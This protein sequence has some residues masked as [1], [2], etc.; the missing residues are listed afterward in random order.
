[1]NRIH[2]A[3]ARFVCGALCIALAFA[4]TP[5]PATAGPNNVDLRA[6]YYTDMEAVSLGGGMLT[7]MGSGWF[8]NPNAE[9]AFGDGGNLLTLNGDFHYDFPTDATVS[10]YLGAG[11]GLLYV[12]PDFGDSDT[13]FG[14]N[15][16]GGVSGLSGSVRPFAQLKSIV[17]DNSELVLT[18]GIRF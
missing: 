6:G 16:I 18:G 5:R 17:S 15:L 7:G 3:S 1:M 14:L 8:F 9:L 4:A 12:N 13:D 11:A 2:S 10:F